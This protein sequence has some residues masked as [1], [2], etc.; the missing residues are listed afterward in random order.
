M[1]KKNVY[2]YYHSKDKIIHERKNLNVY[3]E[4]RD[5]IP[6]ILLKERHISILF[7]IV[8]ILYSITF[9]YNLNIDNRMIINFW[10]I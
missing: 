10:K 8:Y 1:S 5:F 9:V 6:I 2:L 4:E 7:E 3:V